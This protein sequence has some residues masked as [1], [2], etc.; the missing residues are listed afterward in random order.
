MAFTSRETIIAN[1]GRKAG[2]MT[3]KQ[4]K[5]FGTKRQRAAL[6]ANRAKKRKSSASHRPRSKPKSN[7]AKKHKAPARK[8]SAPRK[9]KAAAKSTPKRKNFGQL[10]ALTGNPAKGH[11][12]TKT[13]K[14]RKS[15]ASH[16]SAGYSSK[17][18]GNPGKKKGSHRHHNPGQ[19]GG[20]MEWITG[21]VGAV[22]GGVGAPA[23]TQLVLGTSNT[24]A[25]GYFGN[26]VAVDCWRR[27]RTSL[28][29]VR[30]S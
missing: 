16:K 24:G 27:R 14:K 18:K 4:I 29:P 19:F 13:K 20:P 28:H 21:G 3:A 15:S 2:K 26:A 7:P 11:S 22:I 10:F 6:K 23:L 9:K 17:K 12:M 30:S 8:S 5:F 25:M 1:P